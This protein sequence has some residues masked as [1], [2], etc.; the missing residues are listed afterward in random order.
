[1]NNRYFERKSKESLRNLF[2]IL[3]RKSSSLSII[4][5]ILF[6]FMGI[7]N[8]LRNVFENEFIYIYI[9]VDI[10]METK[11]VVQALRLNTLSKLTFADSKRFDGLVKDVFPSVEFQDVDYETL[12][13][14]LRMSAQEL[15]LVVM[16]TQVNFNV[17]VFNVKVVQ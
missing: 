3:L 17:F 4:T 1:M 7:I 13:V 11:I 9:L 5:L 12:A 2:K 6:A 15:N 10:K 8:D 16:P 14:A